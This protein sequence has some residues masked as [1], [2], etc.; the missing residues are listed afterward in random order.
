MP[1]R[2]VGR[3]RGLGEAALEQRDQSILHGDAQQA[4]VADRGHRVAQDVG[5]QHLVAQPLLAADQQ[6]FA[7]QA[8]ARRPARAIDHE[9]RHL[10]QFRRQPRLVGLPALAQ[11]SQGQ[12]RGR[13]RETHD[14]Q[15]VRIGLLAEAQRRLAVLQRAGGVAQVVPGEGAIVIGLAEAR[16]QPQRLVEEGQR[17]RAVAPADQHRAQRVPQA[18]GARML[19]DG[20]PQQLDRLVEAIDVAQR[21]GQVVQR[22]QVAGPA[23]QEVGEELDRQL[24]HAQAEGQA[25][26]VAGD[27][28]VIRQQLQRRLVA[29]HRAAEI[30]QLLPARRPARA[31][32]RPDARHG[33]A[34]P[35]P[36]PRPR[37]SRPRGAPGS[38]R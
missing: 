32:P 24:G 5:E 22:L 30:A 20:G 1:H 15:V 23:A 12:Q 38:R 10:Q 21:A 2:A 36:S 9:G 34:P 25:A 18:V 4:L 33:P 29:A 6:P 31:R 16:P 26:Q 17:G 14:G 35:G 7:G 37:C 8:L 11:A 13:P 28:P 19:D 27:A 3:D